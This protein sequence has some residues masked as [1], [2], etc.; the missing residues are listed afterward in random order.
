[1]NDEVKKHQRELRRLLEAG[2]KARAALHLLELDRGRLRERIAAI[3]TSAEELQES[4]SAAALLQVQEDYLAAQLQRLDAE[5]SSPT[6]RYGVPGGIERR[7]APRPAPIPLPAFE[8]P[9][10]Q[11]ARQPGVAISFLDRARR[12]LRKEAPAR[13]VS[14]REASA[15]VARTPG[16]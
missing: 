14:A 3:E 9:P 10:A 7:S 15:R 13:E 4:L 2:D 16:A 1:M 5:I 8:A 12:A 11:V 6:D